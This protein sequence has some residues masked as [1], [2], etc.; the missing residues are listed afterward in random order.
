MQNFAYTALDAQGRKR[1]GIVEAASQ[2]AAISQISAQGRFVVDIRV[3]TSAREAARASGFGQKKVSKNDIALLTRRLADMSDA[4][5]PLDRCIRVASEQTENPRLAEILSEA[6][7]DVQGGMSVSAAFSKHPKI[8]NNIYTETLRSGEASGQF[9]QVATR[10]AQFLET[11]VTRRSQIVGAMIYPIIL[12]TVA[13]FAVFFLITFVVPKLTPVFKDMGDDLQWN[14]KLL[15]AV[16][17]FLTNNALLV[18]GLLIGVIVL[19]RG[20]IAT[21]PGKLMRDRLIL[22]LP[23]IGPVTKKAVVSRFARV[24]GTLLFGGVGILESITIAG[25][26]AGNRVFQK[27]SEQVVNDVRE[28]QPVTDAMRQSGVF[29]PVL[30]QMVAIGEDTGDLPKMLNRVSDSLDFEVDNGMRRLTSLIEPAIVI[31][32]GG[33][34]GFIVISILV[35]IIQASEHIK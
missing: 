11:E 18:F 34:V 22:Q 7:T 10:L 35:P 14:T 27:T 19:A 20:Y 30:V 3:D 24:L 5:L 8:F 16:S 13:I 31:L 9:P 21:E 1:S 12:T 2:E 29:P 25:L 4:G 23:V 26:S 17:G 32:M 28:G 6:Y 15:L 33:V